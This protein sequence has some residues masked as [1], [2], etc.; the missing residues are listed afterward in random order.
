[1]TLFFISPAISP[2]FDEFDTWLIGLQDHVGKAQLAL[3]FDRTVKGKFGDCEPVGEGMF[4]M[5]IH[6]GQR[7][8]DKFQPT[9]RSGL[10]AA[11]RR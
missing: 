2:A 7:L 1:V 3:R 4:E 8:S 11:V 9:W 6:Y 5:R 10:S